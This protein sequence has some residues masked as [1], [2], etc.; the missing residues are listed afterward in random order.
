MYNFSISN[1]N[2]VYDI[3]LEK[4]YTDSYNILLKY[5]DN[6]KELEDKF[7][8]IT[9][10]ILNLLSRIKIKDKF[11][12]LNVNFIPISKS[13]QKYN[14]TYYLP[15]YYINNNL[16]VLRQDKILYNNIFSDIKIQYKIQFF[17]I[18]K[19]VLINK[20]F[21]HFDLNISNYKNDIMNVIKTKNSSYECSIC[22]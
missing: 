21:Q 8:V 12:L 2:N 1:S 22:V 10:S 20:I 5:I 13:I 18:Q 17:N 6:Y 7:K 19:T 3:I 14:N 11:L 16:R 4:N 9:L 15:S